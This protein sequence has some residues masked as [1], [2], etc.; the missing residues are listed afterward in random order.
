MLDPISEMLTRIRNAVRAGHL[1]VSMPSSKM[2]VRIAEVLAKEG[3]VGEIAVSDEENGKRTLTI[4]LTYRTVDRT[5][6]EGAIRQITRVSREGQRIYV[7]SADIRPVKNGHGISIIS[8]SQGVM[9][10]KE[11]RKKRLGGEVICEVW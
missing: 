3:F 2:K 7:R 4:D 5:T 10:G 9:T 8:T 1:R 11:A 6:Q